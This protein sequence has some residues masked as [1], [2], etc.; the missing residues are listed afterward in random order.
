MMTIIHGDCLDYLRS[1]PDNAIDLLLTDPP[2]GIDIAKRG[3]VGNGTNFSKKAWDSKR[4]TQEYFFEML[5]VSRN[6]IIWGGNYFAD[7]LPPSRCWLVW[8]KRDNLPVLSFA[9]CEL[10]WTS[11]DRTAMVFNCRWYGFVK[12][13]REKKM[14]PAQKALAVMEWCIEEFSHEGHTIL[15][16]FLGT[17]STG[18]AAKR[19]GRS[20][21][22]IERDREY[23]A[24]A[25]ERL[26]SEK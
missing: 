24:L 11:F 4:P 7:Y 10:A 12:D 19:L 1:L 17:G 16:P 14:H 6:Q 3:Y 25:H 26:R 23:V 9:D 18:V 8:Y 2:Y 13:S 22:G 21:I 15:D 5:R 20:F